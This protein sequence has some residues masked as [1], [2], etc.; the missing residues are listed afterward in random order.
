[1]DNWK[2]LIE[3]IETAETK[4]EENDRYKDL[5]NKKISK[6]KKQKKKIDLLN[7]LK[8]I[9]E[10]EGEKQIKFTNGYTQLFDKFILL[11][12]EQYGL[13]EWDKIKRDTL[14]CKLFWNN[15]LLRSKTTQEIKNR[16]FKLL[17]LL[18]VAT[19]QK[20]KKAKSKQATTSK[21]KTNTKTKNGK[22]SKK[23]KDKSKKNKKKPKKKKTNKTKK[24]KNQKK[25]KAESA[26]SST[27]SSSS[28]SESESESD[29]DRSSSISSTLSNT[30]RKRLTKKYLEELKQALIPN[31]TI[32]EVYD[33]FDKEW[34]K[35]KIIKHVERDIFTLYDFADTGTIDE[36]FKNLKFNILKQVDIEETESDDEDD[37]IDMDKSKS[38]S[39]SNSKSKSRSKSKS[40]SRS[41]SVSSNKSNNSKNKNKNGRKRKLMDD[42][43]PDAKRRRIGL[44][45]RSQ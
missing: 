34:K 28:E 35:Y 9:Y 23:K 5:L 4:R 6:K 44:G 14:K 26:S 11:K 42:T 45:L 43:L 40:V 33:D 17:H 8:L 29:D 24:K 39:K 22:T 21:K 32:I 3:R 38:R 1:M 19:T 18:D 15:W 20:A 10:I 25:N 36:S 41:N 16:A 7:K 2:K 30:S 37:D 31:K 13:N 27:S 12:V